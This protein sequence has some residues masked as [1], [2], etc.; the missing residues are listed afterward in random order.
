M[1]ENKQESGVKKFFS[2]LGGDKFKNIIIVAGLIGIALIF[3]SSFVKIPSSQ[4]KQEQQPR[5]VMTAD[6]YAG[7]LEAS[8][9]DLISSIQG[10]GTAKVMVTLEN[11][12]ETKYA[13]E[14][15]TN[16]EFSEEKT[17]G[18][19]TRSQ[20]IGDSEIKYITVRDANGAERALAVTE[21]QPT[22]KGVVVVCSGGENPVVQQRIIDAVTTA[23]NVSSKRVCVIR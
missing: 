1:Q 21:I 17:N 14:Q 18:E 13:T 19:T 2:G 3:L 15:K 8:L 11:G 4:E 12:V 9:T 20:Q 22:V 7:Q 16:S 5:V 23:L 6:E 10:A